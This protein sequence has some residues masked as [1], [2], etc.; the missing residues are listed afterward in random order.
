MEFLYK[1][2][3]QPIL[4]FFSP[5]QAHEILKKTLPFIPFLD[6]LE[7]TFSIKSKKLEINIANISFKNPI[8]LAAGFDKTGELYPYLSKMG[9]GFVEVGT[10]TGEKQDGNPKPRIFRFPSDLVLVNRLGFNND[11]AILTYER[12]KKQKKTVP[13]GINI[14]K[15][16]I[17]TNEQ[18]FED[19]IKTLNLLAPLNDYAVINISSPNTPNLRELQRKENLQN[20][21]YSIWTN[22]KYKIPIFIKIS[23]DLGYKELSD[24]FDLV[25]DFKIQ[26]IILTNTTIHYSKEKYKQV[27]GLSG[28]PLQKKTTEIIRFTYKE[29]GKKIPIIGVGGIF[30]G[31]SALEKILAGASLIQI[32]TGFIYKGPYIVLNILKYLNEFLEKNNI[33]SISQIVG[34]ESE[35]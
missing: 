9:F 22:L 26:G 4:F 3:I 31:K 6:L 15:T 34:K 7:S 12:L 35:F 23:P 16:K 8:G 24:I 2:L 13:R 28:L 30:C 20:F 5:E 1:H 18:A 17:I 19:Y 10:V 11:G 14:G 32:Y 25:Y 21:L 33:Q 29:I 27:G